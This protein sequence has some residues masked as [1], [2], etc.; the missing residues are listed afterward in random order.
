MSEKNDINKS[1]IDQFIA[2]QLGMK[3]K[4]VGQITDMFLNQIKDQMAQGF[5]TDLHR[6]GTFVRVVRKARVGRNPKTGEAIDIPEKGVVKFK[7][8][9][10][11]KDAAKGV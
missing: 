7:P 11:F 4:D 8:F 6:F 2:D 1:D 9:K 5:D 3:V 10:A